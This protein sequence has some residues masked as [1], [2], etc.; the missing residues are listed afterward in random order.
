MVFMQKPRL[1]LILVNVSHGNERK[2]KVPSTQDVLAHR[3]VAALP[4]T[5]HVLMVPVHVGRAALTPN[6]VRQLKN[7][8]LAMRSKRKLPP[9][10]G[11]LQDTVWHRT[12][13][14]V[15]DENAIRH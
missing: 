10:I 8:P 3:P 15:L 1:R 6:L 7:L 12:R 2:R 14:R 5:A 11:I 9:R 13:K 4:T